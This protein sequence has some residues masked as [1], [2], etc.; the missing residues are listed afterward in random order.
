MAIHSS[1]LAWSIPWTRSLVGYS[2]YSHTESNTT[3]H[4]HTNC[5]KSTLSPHLISDSFS[6][7]GK[8][9]VNVFG[10]KLRGS[11]FFSFVCVQ[12]LNTPDV[13]ADHLYFHHPGGN[14][15]SGLSS[16]V[17]RHLPALDSA[18][19]SVSTIDP[20]HHMACMYFLVFF[21]RL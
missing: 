12:I 6:H 10:L 11:F 13:H 1:I 16:Y 14:H 9:K 5:V 18:A 17:M 20:S 2:P 7:K 15:P 3:G 19:W 8:L 21:I 4:T